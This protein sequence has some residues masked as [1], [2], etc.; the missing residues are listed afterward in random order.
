MAVDKAIEYKMQGNKK[1]A[2]NYL[3]KQKTVSKVPVKW[4]SG[5]DTPPTELAYITEAEKNLLLKADLHGSLKD[6]PNTGPDGIMSL[7]SQ[8]DYT[9]DRSSRGPQ[10]SGGSRQDRDRNE[11]HMREILTGQKNIG[12]TTKTGPKTRK[13]AVPEYVNVK[14]KD[15]TF[16]N[17]YIGSGYKSYGQPSFLGN[18]F[19]RGAP[20]YRGIKGMPAFFGKPG[21]DLKQ[22][23][24]GMGYYSDK[25]NFG[26][27]RDAF[28]KFGLMGLISSLTEKF[29][30]PKDMS[31]FNNLQLVDG[32]LVDTR[33]I[34]SKNIP[35][36]SNI[37]ME[38]LAL[39]NFFNKQT[40]KTFSDPFANT[41]GTTTKVNAPASDAV[42][43]LANPE[44]NRMKGYLDGIELPNS[45]RKIPTVNGVPMIDTGSVYQNNLDFFKNLNKGIVENNEPP[46]VNTDN[47]MQGSVLDA[48]PK[49]GIM[50]MISESLFPE[51]DFQNIKAT[52]P[53]QRTYNIE[54]TKD[55][56]ENNPLGILGEIY[57]PVTSLVTSPFYDATQAFQR[58]E[59]DSG[60][61]GFAKAFNAEEPVSSALER[62]YGATLP[63]A[64]RFANLNN[65]SASEITPATE[66]IT[67]DGGMFNTPF[68]ETQIQPRIIAAEN[69]YDNQGKIFPE[70]VGERIRM[71]MELGNRRGF[72]GPGFADGGLASMFTR[73]G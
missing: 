6:G 44:L 54:A 30:K 65:A 55:L 59:P 31:E 41:V 50:E 56:I 53:D 69:A 60:I 46:M 45:K 8:G 17:K 24:D 25:E 14:Q 33:N 18:L 12:Q 23:P 21:F 13:Y 7:D 19:S 68:M 39:Q 61:K 16:K 57:A 11:Q 71:N 32:E 36:P 43:T 34:E 9:R 67:T 35:V 62:A 72:M 64:E 73:R 58:M 48:K 47:V 10:R 22:G 20:G 4:Q 70:S 66:N 38:S 63:L 52:A 5:P 1:P 15:G 2:K 51:G 27:T 3:G 29:R 40:P 37:G 26:E 42:S 28:P 49:K